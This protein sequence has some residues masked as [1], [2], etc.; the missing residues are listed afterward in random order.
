RRYCS[1]VTLSAGARVGSYE[2]I[3]PLGAGGMGEVYRAFDPRLRREVAIKIISGVS[4]DSMQRYR[5]E[6]EARAAGG[7]NHPNLLT[8]HELGV[9]EEAPFIVCEL[10]VGH[11]LRTQ[12]LKGPLPAA[13]A[14]DFALQ[15]ARGLA[16]AHDKGIVH[17]DLK[18]ENIFITA[19]G[20]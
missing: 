10:L 6:Q 7:L 16:A 14:A 4:F 8:I 19:D 1:W 18:P 12:L 5:L 20:R 15:I 11:T 9:H 17:R 2:I 13:Q 3:E